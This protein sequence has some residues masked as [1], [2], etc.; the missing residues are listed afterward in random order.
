[1]LHQASGQWKLGLLLALV[2]AFCWATLPLVLKMTL[3]VMDP[4]TLTWFRFLFAAVFMFFWLSA[5]KQLVVYKAIDAKRLWILLAAALLL[6]GNYVGYLFGVYYTTPANA[7]LLIQLAPLLMA[8]GGVFVFKE[9]FTRG[10]WFGLFIICIGMALFFRDQ[11]AFEAVS[12]ASYLLGSGIIVLAAF[13]WAAYAL[14]Q[15]QL[16][17]KL[18]SQHIL[19][20]IYLFSALALWPFAKPS[21]LFELNAMNWGLL[22][23]CAINTLVAYGAFAEALAHWQASRVSAILASTPLL[24]LL[25]VFIVHGIW[26]NAIAEEHVTVLGIIGALLVVLGSALSSLLGQKS[27]T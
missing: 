11:I 1:M 6:I 27:K 24:C 10:Q 18:P 8:L 3:R 13:S 12:N 21:A 19:S 5:K 25:A 17:M 16:L 26:P 14:L 22:L 7:Q 9:H 23:F 15:K 20:F 4:I 2:T